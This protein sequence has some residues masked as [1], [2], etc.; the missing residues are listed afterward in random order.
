[1]IAF[2][3]GQKFTLLFLFVLSSLVLNIVTLCYI[4]DKS[5]KWGK[6]ASIFTLEH[7]LGYIQS[8]IK[9][10]K[11]EVKSINRDTGNIH[12]HKNFQRFFK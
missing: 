1:M 5:L 8:D 2:I 6:T 10:I 12:R 3:K 11:R 4:K 9:D 7:T